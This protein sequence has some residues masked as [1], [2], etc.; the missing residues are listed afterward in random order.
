MKICEGI[1]HLNQGDYVEKLA[2]NT[3]LYLM[4]KNSMNYKSFAAKL[5]INTMEV[6]KNPQTGK[7][8][9]ATNVG[10]F[11]VENNIDYDKPL[12]FLWE[13]DN[14]QDACLINHRET[15]VVKNLTGLLA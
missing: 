13:D 11:K 2:G 4:A 7:L 6:V 9:L 10:K 3:P 1:D 8:F 15:N 5:G 14:M 12:D